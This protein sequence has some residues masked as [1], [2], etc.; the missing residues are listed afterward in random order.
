M[1]KSPNGKNKKHT[2]KSTKK[3]TSSRK[4]TN[5]RSTRTIISDMAKKMSRKYILQSTQK[6]KTKL[7]TKATAMTRKKASKFIQPTQEELERISNRKAAYKKDKKAAAKSKVMSKK[8]Q[9]QIASQ[10]FNPFVIEKVSDNAELDFFVDPCRVLN[11]LKEQ[12]GN[13]NW[14]FSDIRKLDD[15]LPQLKE[16][17]PGTTTKVYKRPANIFKNTKLVYGNNVITLKDKIGSGSN[18]VIRKASYN[19]KTI[20]VKF[21]NYDD[22]DGINEFLMES[23]MQ[24]EIWCDLRKHGKGTFLVPKIEFLG[25]VDTVEW[26]NKGKKIEKTQYVI[27]MEQLDGDIHS[28]FE[29]G[30]YHQEILEANIEFAMKNTK[31]KTTAKAIE[32]QTIG[33][34]N[35]FI[36]IA[37]KL[38][39]LQDRYK[40]MHRDFHGSNVMYKKDKNGKKSWCVI[41][42]GMSTAIPNTEQ[43]Y[44]VNQIRPEDS[45]Y[46]D[47]WHTDMTKINKSQDMR[48]MFT[49]IIRYLMKWVDT[50][51]NRKKMEWI[52]DVS[53]SP[54]K[55]PERVLRIKKQLVNY[56]LMV[57]YIIGILN[58]TGHYTEAPMI[59]HT[60]FHNYYD[61]VYAYDDPN[62]Y[63]ENIIANLKKILEGKDPGIIPLSSENIENDVAIALNYNS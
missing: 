15:I 4:S 30:G 38:K 7:K 13:S 8:L 20:A 27:G 5:R 56:L 22:E 29:E 31:P 32:R 46:D 10:S 33:V 2:G 21:C 53:S 49:S 39:M 60:L 23:M 28:F 37:S 62:F 52:K 1:G 54:K 11:K 43:N 36:E 58:L 24:N 25:K 41:D 42:F 18:G 44:F 51:G 26:D 50:P 34:I 16:K 19:D 59:S 55:Q 14:K 35:A 3:R 12:I 6:I 57:K 17:Y 47:W 61:Q 9:D 48:I 40:L 45:F 63:P